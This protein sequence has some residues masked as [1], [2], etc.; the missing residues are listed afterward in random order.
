M[1]VGV[2]RLGRQCSRAR[3]PDDGLQCRRSHAALA[4]V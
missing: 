3:T 2:G 1:N 4:V